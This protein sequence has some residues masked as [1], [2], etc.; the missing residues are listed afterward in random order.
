V[1]EENISETMTK[2]YNIAND[3]LLEEKLHKRKRNRQK[4]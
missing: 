1:A 2:A 4:G 3:H